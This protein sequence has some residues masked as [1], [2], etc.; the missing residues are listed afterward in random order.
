MPIYD[1]DN[2]PPHSVR[3]GGIPTQNYEAQ[4]GRDSLQHISQKPINQPYRFLCRMLA[5]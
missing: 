1:F 4:V 3:S 5:K 2:V